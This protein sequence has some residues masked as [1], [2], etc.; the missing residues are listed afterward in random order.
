M[1]YAGVDQSKTYN[2]K[3]LELTNAVIAENTKTSDTNSITNATADN[4]MTIN[5]RNITSHGHINVYMPDEHKISSGNSQTTIST[6]GMYI[7]Q[8]GNETKYTLQMSAV[9]KN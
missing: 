5:G 1:D 7:I 3:G 9:A 6:K 2:V 4:S 8:A